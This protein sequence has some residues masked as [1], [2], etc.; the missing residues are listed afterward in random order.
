VPVAGIWLLTA[1]LGY[2]MHLEMFTK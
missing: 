2:W 1:V